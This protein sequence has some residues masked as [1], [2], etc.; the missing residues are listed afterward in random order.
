[1]YKILAYLYSCLK[2]GEPVDHKVV[3]CSGG[4]FEIPYVYWAQVMRQ[5][6]DAGYI[7]GVVVTKTWGG[8]VIVR[9]VEPTVTLS[10]V[11]FM[12]ENGA[13]K[14]ALRFLQETKS[15]LPFV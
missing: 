9:L 15:A 4:M 3:S 14:K 1:M 7:D 10:G 5:L 8:D 11:E 12:Q 13:M 6:V 2:S